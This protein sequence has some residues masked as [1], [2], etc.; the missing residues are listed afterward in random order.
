M[1]EIKLSSKE[2]SKVEK[3]I[4]SASNLST[5]MKDVPDNTEITVMVWAII[6]H[7]DE[8]TGESTNLLSIFDGQH[9][10]VAQSQTF[11]D[12]FSYISSIMEDVPYKIKK[13]SGTSK[14]DRKFIDCQLVIDDMD[15]SNY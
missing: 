3:Y 15:F 13:I 4:M 6:E 9:V 10:Y 12:S 7:T 5:S 14:S 8:Y 1:V 2:L 11:F